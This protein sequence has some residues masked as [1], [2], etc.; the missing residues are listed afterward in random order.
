MSLT[1]AE[2]K[3]ILTQ[4]LTELG[5]TP[6]ADAV[7]WILGLVW[8]ESRF[9]TT[10]DWVMPNALNPNPPFTGPSNNWGAVR[11]NQ[12]DGLIVN[13]HD[14]DANGKLGVYPFQA[15]RTPVDGAKGF[16]KRAFLRGRVPDIIKGNGTI[17]DL[18]EAMFENHYY[19][20]TTGSTA[21]RINAYASLI[22][23]GADKVRKSLALPPDPSPVNPAPGG[24]TPMNPDG[25]GFGL[26]TVVGSALALGAGYLGYRYFKRR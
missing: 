9:G 5:V 7:F 19:T 25:D 2:A 10:P 6:T 21:D 22:K 3:D 26:G 8:G 15:Y 20:G 14:K 13:H 17:H 24:A 23:S 11:Y 1:I 12:G 18:A 4:A 16:L